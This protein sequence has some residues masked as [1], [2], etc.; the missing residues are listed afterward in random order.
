MQPTLFI[1]H[2]SPMLAL[3]DSPARRFLQG[4]GEQLERPKAVVAVS[5]HWETD[6]PMVNSV[7]RNDTIHDFYG[8]PQ[9]LFQVQYQAP[10]SAETANRLG[11]L[12]AEA[13]LRS[14]IDARRGLDHGAWV[15][16]SLMWPEADI[17]V[18]QLS[19]QSRLGPGHHWQLGRALAALRAENV[20][21]MAS[22]SFTHNLRALQR[23]APGAEPE[24][25]TRFSEWMHEA[26]M[27]NR[28]CDLVSYRR[29]AP[30]AVENHPTDEHLLPLFVAMGAAGDGAQA[31]RL[32][33]S[34]E[35]GSLRM[36][37]YLFS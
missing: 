32:H 18:V 27:A 10:G 28:T 17:P 7:E 36:D 37:S 6:V 22:G 20:L 4:L 1:S 2:G 11:D 8:F 35:L 3:E 9:A 13:G 33:T 25:V 21:V 14:G 29:L 23:L 16:L 26:I 24:W 31:Q 30:F 5:A 34:V 19:I 12:L 15:P